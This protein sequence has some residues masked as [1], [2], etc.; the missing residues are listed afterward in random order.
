MSWKLV[1]HGGSG[2]RLDDAGRHGL[3]AALDAGVKP[4][5]ARGVPM[6]EPT[7]EGAP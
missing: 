1:I 7:K 2:T 3:D 5:D 6:E 4:R